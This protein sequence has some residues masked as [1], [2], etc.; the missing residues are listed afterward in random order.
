MRRVGIPRATGLAL[1]AVLVV[2]CHWHLT[3]RTQPAADTAKAPEFSLPD[4]S[5]NTV[6]LS[7][8]LAKGPVVVVFYR[9]Y[10]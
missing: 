1:V 3:T 6:A 4:A 10:W 5:G 8:L 9:G 7:E 2:A